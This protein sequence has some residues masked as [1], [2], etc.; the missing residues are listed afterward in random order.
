MNGS[1][2]GGGAPPK[3]VAETPAT[4]G[5]RH[6][7]PLAQYAHLDARADGGVDDGRR[8]RRHGALVPSL[9]LLSLAHSPAE[10]Q[11]CAP[12]LVPSVMDPVLAAGTRV[13]QA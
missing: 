12:L 6:G 4:A 3:A 11:G 7:R 8:G 1:R 9:T 2:N 5:P 10:R 13:A